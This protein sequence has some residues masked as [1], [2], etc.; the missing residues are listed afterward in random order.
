MDMIFNYYCYT[1]LGKRVTLPAGLTRSSLLKDFMKLS[2]HDAIFVQMCLN[3]SLSLPVLTTFFFLEQECNIY[4]SINLSRV[5]F[6][7]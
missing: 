7:I 5:F 6:E 1:L 3:K 2:S 4:N